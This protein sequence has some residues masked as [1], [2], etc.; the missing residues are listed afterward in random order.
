MNALLQQLANHLTVALFRKE[1]K[2]MRRNNDTHVRH[3]LQL[4]NRGFLKLLQGAKMGCQ[5]GGC[6]FTNF[7]DTQRV[8]ETCE[9]RLFGFFQR[10][11]HVL[12]RFWPH[13]IQPGQLAR[14]QAEQI[15][16]RVDVLF[17]D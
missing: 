17:L 16:R 7:T 12:R 1:V 4:L 14:R 11:D 3:F 9:G 2:D 10:I 15:R 13:A 5:P 8:Q 6:R